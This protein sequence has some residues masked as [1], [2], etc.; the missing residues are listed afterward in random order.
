MATMCK[1]I[2]SKMRSRNEQNVNRRKGTKMHFI[3]NIIFCFL[4]ILTINVIPRTQSLDL[5][6]INVPQIVD[7]RDTVTLLCNY[8]MGRDKLHSV[9]WYKDDQEFYRYSPTE[10]KRTF[11]VMGVTIV[12][13]PHDECNRR[14][15]SISLSQLNSYSTGVYKCEVSGDA[16]AFPVVYDSRNM[17]VYALPLSDPV[18]TGLGQ[19]YEIGDFVF[20]NCTSDISYPAAH[21]SWYINDVKATPDQLL[22]QRENKMDVHGF[23]LHS[24]TL[25]MRFAIDKSRFN[26]ARIFLKCVARIKEVPNATRESTHMII[27]PKLQVQKE[28]SLNY[29][30]DGTKPQTF[31][32]NIFTIL[33]GMNL[34]PKICFYVLNDN[35]NIIVR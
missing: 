1:I 13:Q 33:I 23:T 10:S 8:S 31:Y 12:H 35:N 16:P 30:S 28:M 20:A 11:P 14:H 25:N 15:C 34:I 2:C 3:W 27:V 17:T 29:R 7:V 4:T 18:V 22:P 19:R 9:K 26:E 5:T 6:D 21:L 24:R 32:Q